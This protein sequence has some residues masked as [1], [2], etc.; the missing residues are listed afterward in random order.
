ME[1][2]R[3]FN[4]NVVLAK[5][6]H[7]DEVILTGRGLGFQTKPGAH[8]D[9]TKVVRKFIP[10]DGR[11]PD[12]MAE[13]LSC[14]SPDII[15]LVTDDMQASGLK[16]LSQNKPMLVMALSDH[17]GFALQRIKKG[18]AVEYPLQAEVEHL[19]PEEYAKANELL[20]A[21]NAKLNDV[22]PKAE[23]IAFAL[24]LVNAGF[25]SGDLTY[26]YTMTGIIQQMLAV[27]ESSCN[28]T[29]DSSSI[30][31]GRFIT[32]LRYLFVRIHQH[33]Q[34]EGDERSPIA[35]AIMQS[36]P[37]AMDCAQKLAT[38]VELRFDVNLTDDEI[39]YLALHVYRVAQ[40]PK[41][42]S[43]NRQ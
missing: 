28:V 3:V 39:A 42:G 38:I 24:H 36:Y 7:A 19:Y 25:S 23:A 2:L 32:H 40:Q 27:V 9:P 35:T 26:T 31:V 15:Q 8:V 21:L 11:D 5:D 37:E 10:S 29:L 33:K 34:L 14:I 22:L 17:V 6:D 41:V 20:H 4:N 13:M 43:K 30:N 16:E 18:I 1:I 12:H